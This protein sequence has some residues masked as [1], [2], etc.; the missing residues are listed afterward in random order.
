MK[1]AGKKKKA[2]VPDVEMLVLFEQLVVDD[3]ELDGFPG[4]ARIEG[5]SALGADVIG[6]SLG[7]AIFGAVVDGARFG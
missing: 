4:L 7:R 3:G 5:Q 2:A 1:W 6:T